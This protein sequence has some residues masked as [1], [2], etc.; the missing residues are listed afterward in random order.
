MGTPIDE[1]PD[2]LGQLNIKGIPKR[3]LARY[4][5]TAARH[6]RSVQQWARMVLSAAARD[7]AGLILKL[8][9]SK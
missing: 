1:P 2:E 7:D 3:E 9:D 8:G 6:Q 5:E 4:A